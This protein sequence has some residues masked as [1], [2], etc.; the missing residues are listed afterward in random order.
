MKYLIVLSA[1]L[2]HGCATTVP[3]K[4]ELPTPPELIT[5]RCP[6]LEVVKEDEEKLSEFMKVIVRNYTL[7][8]EC[9]AKHD[10]LVKWIGEQKAIHDETFNK[11][12]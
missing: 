7:Y 12:K 10:L 8:Y 5:E 4:H 6:V 1:F 9:S 11:G 2:L 3:V